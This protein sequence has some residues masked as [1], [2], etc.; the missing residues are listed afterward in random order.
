M[1]KQITQNR[2]YICYT[3]AFVLP[4]ILMLIIV[5]SIKFYPFGDILPLVADMDVQFV[6]YVAYLKSVLFGNNDLLYTFSKTLGGDMAGFSFYYLGNPFIYILAIIPTEILPAGIM[7]MII[8]IMAF[9]SL[10][11]NI[12]INRM[13]GYRFASVIFSVSYAF[14][15]FFT[16]YY[17][18]MLYFFNVSIL[19]LIILG[20]Y[21]IIIKEKRSYRYIF[22]L[23]LSIITN[24]Y[25][26]YMTC[27]FSVIFAGYLCS[28]KFKSFDEIKSK[29]NI[30]IKY[31]TSSILA[32]FISAISLITVFIS[33]KDQKMDQSG[34]GFSLNFNF[35]IL[36][37]FSE[38][39]TTGFNGNIS[40][41]LPVIY[42][43]I[44]VVVF[45]ILFFLN[46]KFELKEKI[47]AAVVIFIMIISFTWDF[48]NVI[49]HG[50]AH[51]VGFPYRNSFFLSFFFIFI[52]YK[53]FI[54]IIKGI[55][56]EHV[57]TCFI[58]YS[59]YSAYMIISNNVYV[60]RIQLILTTAF[61]IMILAGIYA[62]CYKREY[63]YPITFGFL[64]ILT[65]DLLINGYHSIKCYFT[66]F[67]TNYNR[68][69]IET[70]Q[71]FYNDTKEIIDTI[72]ENDTDF[73]RIDKCYNRSHNDAMLIGYNS[74]SHFS[75]CETGTVKKF[76]EKLGYCTS[77][78]WSYYGVEGST[79]FTDS[80]LSLKYLI[81]QYDETAKGYNRYGEMNGK[82]IYKNQYALPLVYGS[83]KSI[84]ELDI[85][86]YNHFTVQNSIAKALTDESFG[87]YRPVEITNIKYV[88]VEREENEYKRINGDEEAYIE[89]ELKV[90]SED[91]IYMFLYGT[92]DQKTRLVINGDEKLDYFFTYNRGIREAGHFKVG[93]RVP[94]RVYLCQDQIE[95]EG[96]EFYYENKDELKR[97]FEEENKTISNVNIVKSSH[98]IIDTS[99]DK[100]DDMLIFSIPYDE[101]WTIKIDGNKV[102]QKKVIDCLMAVEVSEGNHKIE[103]KYVPK[104][105][106]I[107]AI[108]TNI[109]LI[110][111][112]IM[113][114]IDE[115]KK[116]K[117]IK[118]E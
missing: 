23:A 97:F 116:K 14:I 92:S 78:M 107:G 48:L 83:T 24:Y 17:D 101:G 82:Y 55:K 65:F 11:F 22:C 98:I 21:E 38:M 75:S 34:F 16:A 44:L 25:I 54:N 111:L 72:K 63:L 76:M 27:F 43:S 56:K 8:I 66:D 42:S 106:I 67:D 99:V 58:I 117:L 50:F 49:W 103:M 2:K 3:A 95:V 100:E 105:L 89:Y 10:N 30:V 39:Y 84:E 70:Y 81:S 61:I 29:I 88:N 96:Y 51:P 114:F 112:L 69:T 9:S 79:A 85:S 80:I 104:G 113:L 62:I 12:M 33:L 110:H 15:G 109:S 45:A 31:V 19:P 37:I 74:L 40:N 28:V 1:I 52:A 94:V 46:K 18:C 53:S 57:I 20:I 64:I 60:G 115:K 35:N 71:N 93:E 7:F 6:S 26:G 77:M 47:G 91:F 4:I 102:E 118:G 73:Y 86:E 59:V 90:D 68:Y 5:S 108:I 41:G 36:D 13:F 32:V 87:I